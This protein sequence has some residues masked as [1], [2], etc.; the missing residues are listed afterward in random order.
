MTVGNPMWA[1]WVCY[2]DQRD[3]LGRTPCRSAGLAC[4]HGGDATTMTDDIDHDDRAEAEHTV[5][6]PL[7]DTFAALEAELDAKADRIERLESELDRTYLDPGEGEPGAVD[8]DET[9]DEAAPRTHEDWEPATD[10]L[11]DTGTVAGDAD[12]EG[13]TPSVETTVE[14]ADREEPTV[15]AG[16]GSEQSTAVDTA[17]ESG[18]S[19]VRTASTDDGGATVEPDE[20]PAEDGEFG[21][22][23][24]SSTNLTGGSLGSSASSGGS[25]SAPDGPDSENES[26][27]DPTADRGERLSLL[28]RR[29]ELRDE[30]EVVEAFVEGID[31]LDDVTWEMLA[32][33]REVGE[34]A[35]VDAH[36]AAGGSGKRQYAYARNRTLRKAG[37]IEHGG[38][39]RYRYA[40]P[41]L[42]AEAFDG[43]AAEEAVSDAVDAIEAATD[44]A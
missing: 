16:T 23:M 40:L 25:G 21:V 22:T 27:P 28:V 1:E 7:I 17:R 4:R 3:R 12:H 9:D 34:A 19:P 42:V 11:D 35:P 31:A 26:I 30:G 5:S 15:A 39:G 44:L 43:N 2:D 38:A 13:V 18:L 29:A 36:V 20:Q 37:V 41:D 6:L 32:H 10:P 8:A 14:G 33:Y 24:E